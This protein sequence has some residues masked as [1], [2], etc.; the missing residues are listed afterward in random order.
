MRRLAERYATPVPRY[1]SYPTAPNFGPTVGAREA[2]QWIALLPDDAHLSL[3]MHIPFC[4]ALCWYCGCATTVVNGHQ[5]I[6]SYVETLATE[7]ARVA[8]LVPPR[9]SV[10]HIH[11]GGGSP[12]SLTA[13]EI[14]AL[15]IRTR[16]LFRIDPAAEFAVE[17]DPRFMDTGRVAALQ[18]AGVN[19]ISI[20]VQDF[21]PKVQAAIN[22]HQPYDK[23]RQVVSDL[24]GAGLTSLNID[25]VYG[26]PGQTQNSVAR[27]VDLVL[28]L[29]PDRIA[30]FGYA[31]LPDK[32]RH[33]RLIDTAALAG[34]TERL[35]QANRIAR[36]LLANG[37]VRV[38]LDH[39][40]K[41]GDPM[42]HAAV[43]RNFQGYTTD[44]ADAL[45]GFGASAISRFPQGYTQ[46]APRTPDYQNRIAERGLATVRGL[47][48]S[49]DDRIRAYVI[50]RLMCDLTFSEGDLRTQF[51]TKAE[52]L[53][54]EARA[55]PEADQDGLIA[56]TSDGFHVTERGRPFVR[57]IC[58]CFD[59]Y[60]DQSAGRHAA[61]V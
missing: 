33:Q 55:L 30:V 25:L 21:D 41:P 31:H 49:E 53:I 48:L 26:L 47:A 34:P 19:R 17:I 42:A 6:A 23:T 24:R 8:E 51:G 16:E 20:G 58:A 2:A 46:N 3:Y 11:W 52:S 39:F 13:D 7:M 56:S 5:P 12:N 22:R 15:A 50:E 43:K 35:G 37:Y 36:I 9:H 18:E 59:T 14:K 40:A 1:T 60:Y 32:I 45:I 4:R 54:E 28:A 29:N 38:G 10:S 57:S 44:V 27:T 61:G